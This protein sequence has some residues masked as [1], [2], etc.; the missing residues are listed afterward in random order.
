MKRAVKVFFVMLIR[1]FWER[2]ERGGAV[3]Q[4]NQ[5]GDWKVG[6]FSSP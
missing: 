1:N 2:S 4:G 6:T 5:A 3:L